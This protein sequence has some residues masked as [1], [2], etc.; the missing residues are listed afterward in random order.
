MVDFITWRF[1]F[2]CC[3]WWMSVRCHLPGKWRAATW[4]ISL[5]TL[6]HNKAITTVANCG[7]KLHPKTCA[8]HSGCAMPDDKPIQLV[9]NYM[10]YVSWDQIITVLWFGTNC[11]IPCISWSIALV[12][13]RKCFMMNVSVSKTTSGE[14]EEWDL[15]WLK[16]FNKIPPISYFERIPN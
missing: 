4:Y 2:S 5:R 14:G 11:L 6:H 9:M 15:A 13:S 8:C 10:S 3:W 7:T 12:L 1:V 16:L